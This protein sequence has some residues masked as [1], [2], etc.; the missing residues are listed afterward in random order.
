MR[1]FVV[2]AILAASPSFAQEEPPIIP[3]PICNDGAVVGV[4]LIISRPVQLAPQVVDLIPPPSMCK[5]GDA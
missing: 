4:R 2:A 3:M 5:G 1:A